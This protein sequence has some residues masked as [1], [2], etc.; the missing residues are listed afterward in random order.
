ML[1]A[2]VDP[3]LFVQLVSKEKSFSQKVDVTTALEK[4]VMEESLH[5]RTKKF[6]GTPEAILHLSR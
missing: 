5:A 3:A 2:L 6:L 4:T 1:P